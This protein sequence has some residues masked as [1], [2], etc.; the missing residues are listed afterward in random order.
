MAKKLITSGGVATWLVQAS[1]VGW[2]RS[3]LMLAGT[4]A[5]W[6]VEARWWGG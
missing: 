3:W 1:G 2:L 5:M 4:V 6:L